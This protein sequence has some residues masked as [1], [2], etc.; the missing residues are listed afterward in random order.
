M[1]IYCDYCGLSYKY[2]ICKDCKASYELCGCETRDICEDCLEAYEQKEQI[3]EQDYRSKAFIH[4]CHLHL[5]ASDNGM[6]R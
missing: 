3:Y 4:L 1:H 2:Y 6:D 5:W